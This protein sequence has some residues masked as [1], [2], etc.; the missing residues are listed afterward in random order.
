MKGKNMVVLLIT[1][2]VM[3]SLVSIAAYS[4][5]AASVNNTN[6]AVINTTTPSGVATF[7]TIGG[8]ASINVT[9]SAMA[10]SQNG[11]LAGS[12]ETTLT[13][14]LKGNDATQVF[15]TYD[16]YFK[17][18]GGYVK[19]SSASD[20][21][22]EFTIEAARQTPTGG[23]GN[24]TTSTTSGTTSYAEK[25]IDATNAATGYKI[26]PN[27][28]IYS[29][30]QATTTVVY[31]VSMKFYNLTDIQNQTNKSYQGEFSVKNVV[32]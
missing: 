23:S 6:V 2:L 27:Q 4:Y 18:S 16:V 31:K 15:C 8:S 20:S 21:N 32:C 25:Q 29:T 24:D 12:N 26:L 28:K 10:L 3:V 30:N 14:T 1:I 5:F 11:T 22:K 17:L 7:T 13:V 9:A 19:T